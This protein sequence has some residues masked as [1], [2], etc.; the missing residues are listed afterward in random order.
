MTIP[1]LLSIFRLILA[2]VFAA[3]FFAP[4]A[5]ARYWAAGVYALAFC[6]DVADGY[7]A[8]RFHQISRLGRI[9]DPLADKLMTFVVIICITVSG[10]I[11]VWAVVVF[12]LKEIT[13]GLGALFLYRRV[14]DVMAANVLGKISTGVF[15]A[16]CAL[17]VLFPD[18]P[19]PWAVGMISLAL[20]L[21]V[22][23][24]ALYVK[25]ALGVLKAQ[26]NLAQEEKPHQP[27]S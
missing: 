9:L 16:V 27:R 10:V 7:I 20:G 13:M 22:L 4:I 1:N 25:Q 5:T 21:A 6:T 24:L 15:F 26:E 18:I 2:P 23:A 17:L 3:V 19:R 12:F 11:P 8:R 14:K